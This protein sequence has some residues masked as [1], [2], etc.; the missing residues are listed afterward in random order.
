MNCNPEHGSLFPS[1][2]AFTSCIKIGWHGSLIHSCLLSLSFSS[3]PLL[4]SLLC[5]S[6]ALHSVGL[7]SSVW[8]QAMSSP[9]TIVPI[10]YRCRRHSATDSCESYTSYDSDE[11][12]NRFVVC[13]QH[14][15]KTCQHCRCDY[16][17]VPECRSDPDFARYQFMHPIGAPEHLPLWWAPEFP[18]HAHERR[19]LPR[20][21]FET[22]Q[23]CK[24]DSEWR[25]FRKNNPR[26]TLLFANGT[27]L[28]HEG[29]DARGGCGVLVHDHLVP[30][31]SAGKVHLRL[32][33]YDPRWANSMNPR[34]GNRG[35]QITNRAE[36]RAVLL[37]L[38]FRPWPREGFTSVVIA[39]SSEYVVRTLAD[40][41]S[42]RAIDDWSR[43][44][45][46]RPAIIEHQDLWQAVLRRVTVLRHCGTPVFVWL[47][48]R[49]WNADANALARQGAALPAD[50]VQMNGS[51]TRQGAALPA[52]AVRMNGSL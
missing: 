7:P 2:D 4:I 34:T 42:V 24:H 52:D 21:L 22:R 20:E 28:Y 36:L 40:P 45:T 30:W 49:E 43:R 19:A 46:Y 27:C 32:E 15:Q 29:S 8:I 5:F 44:N 12:F 6:S 17:V 48:P 41:G 47:I 37:A 3:L 31:P 35:V 39:S 10:Q 23:H 26:Q 13:T 16:S 1:Q 38:M 9:S 11:P 25:F 51:V 18:L 14:L 33:P 50:A